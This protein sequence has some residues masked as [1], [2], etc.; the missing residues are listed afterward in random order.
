MRIDGSF[1]A[2]SQFDTAVVDLWVS[3]FQNGLL[4]RAEVS[5]G[6]CG[7]LQATPQAR[8][9][10]EQTDV[11]TSMPGCGVPWSGSFTLPFQFPLSPGN[12]VVIAMRVTVQP[13]FSEGGTVHAAFIHTASLEFLPP[14]GTTVT[15]ATGQT[16]GT[17]A[18][19]PA[20]VPE[21]A[22]MLL[23]GTGLAGIAARKAAQKGLSPEARRLTS[24]RRSR[25]KNG[26]RTRAPAAG[27]LRARARPVE[28]PR[29]RLALRRAVDARVP[30]SRSSPTQLNWEPHGH[31]T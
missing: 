29:V 18:D 26:R 23:L 9:T 10:W 28:P 20:A 14:P 4:S 21:P 11:P 13:S 8:L 24:S 22:S 7:D 19:V 3:D 16:F 31:S 1:G 25:E 12:G 15:L 17:S 6:Q 27:R 30:S 5:F 2:T